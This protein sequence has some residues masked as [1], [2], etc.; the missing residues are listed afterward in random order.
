MYQLVRQLTPALAISCRQSYNFYVKVSGG[1]LPM[2]QVFLAYKRPDAERV[3]K[4][5]DK[6]AALGI[7]LFVDH[8]IQGG[9]DYIAKINEELNSARA[10]L[11]FWSKS[12][13]AL[14]EPGQQNFLMAEAQKGWRRNILIAATF[15]KV[16]LDNLPVP[17][18]TM[19][20]SDLSDWFD[21]GMCASHYGWQRLLDAL[22]RKIERPG[23]SALALST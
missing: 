3:S 9:D 2:S 19:Q 12:A 18:N 5:R 1:C 20:T 11:V 21:A 22:G 14:T 10:A 23:L 15:D 7:E 17:F 6:L 16:V 13:I 8:L 4:V